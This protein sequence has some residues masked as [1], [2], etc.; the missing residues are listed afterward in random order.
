MLDASGRG[1]LWQPL[2]RERVKEWFAANP[3]RARQYARELLM[4]DTPKRVKEHARN[5][6]ARKRGALGSVSRGFEAYL[7]ELQGSRCNAPW[8]RKALTAK[9]RNFPR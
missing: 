5:Y 8:C 4:S 7:M 3:E 2:H 6:K 1:P 9:P